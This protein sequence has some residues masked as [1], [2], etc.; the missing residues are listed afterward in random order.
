MACKPGLDLVPRRKPNLLA[1]HGNG[2]E[3]KMKMKMKH[4]EGVTPI[5]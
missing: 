4:N 2:I 5:K 3:L 1:T